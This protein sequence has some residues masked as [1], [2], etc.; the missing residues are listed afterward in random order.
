M[1][2]DKFK[3]IFFDFGDTIIHQQV[4]SETPLDQL[5]LKLF[6][7]IQKVLEHVSAHCKLGIISNTEITND[8]AVKH[9]LEKL[10]IAQFFETVTTSVSTGIKKPNKEI[11]WV[12]L[13]KHE[14][15]SDESMMVGNNYEEDI[16]PAKIVGMTTVLY[17]VSNKNMKQQFPLA[18]YIVKNSKEL[19]DLFKS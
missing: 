15:N 10:Q 12:A 11:F 3:T 16:V 6:P 2:L 9:A 17:G 8:T 13:K 5:P 4:D 18:D 1:N 14:A 7:G 19:L